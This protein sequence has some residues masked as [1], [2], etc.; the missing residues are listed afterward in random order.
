M[1]ITRGILLDAGPL[2]AAFDERDEHHAVCFDRLRTLH[3]PLV[4]TWPVLTE[5][6]YFLRGDPEK[7]DAP[8]RFAARPKVLVHPLNGDA[9]DWIRQVLGRYESLGPQV[10]DASL[11][12]LADALKL[13][14]ILTLDRRD[15]GAYRKRDKSALRIIP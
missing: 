1:R 13:D 8:F 2:I 9:L 5:A 4:T 3:A 14:T 6:A 12:Y 15:F 7:L 11:M 10:A